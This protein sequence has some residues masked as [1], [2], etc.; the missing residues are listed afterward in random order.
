MMK[1]F[2][3]IFSFLLLY[4][5]HAMASVTLAAQPDNPLGNN[6][7]NDSIQDQSILPLADGEMHYVDFMQETAGIHSLLKAMDQAHVSDSM[8]TGLPVAKKWSANA[9]ER[10]RYFQGDDASVYWFSGTDEIVARAIESL[11]LSQQK[12]FH[13]F[14]SGFNPT[15]LNAANHIERQLQW[16]PGF[17]QGIGEI[18]TRHDDLTALTDGEK[19]RVNHPALHRVYQLAAK[20]QLPVLIHANITSARED[21]PLYL[22]ELEEAFSKNPDTTFI[23]AHAG[24]SSATLRNNDLTF[25]Q[26]LVRQLLEKYDNLNIMLS[27]TIKQLIYNKNG[28]PNPKWIKLV[29][30]YPDR[31]MLGSD[32]VGRFNSLNKTMQSYQLFLKALPEKTA[33]VLARGNFLTIVKNK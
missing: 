29:N 7:K 3:F 16:R 10:P 13:P 2:Q 32:L 17:W 4:S 8:L 23:W 18:L 12:R 9:P 24:T 11:P 19:A 33:N 30:D 25:V 31:F 14:I 15:D 5:L 28:Q 1:I 22:D 20:H 27:W 21:K 6:R 26:P